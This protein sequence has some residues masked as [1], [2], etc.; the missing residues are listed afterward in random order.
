MHIV[1]RVSKIKSKA[2][3]FTIRIHAHLN[4]FKF[5]IPITVTWYKQDGVLP[6]RSYQEHGT[7]TI[8]NAQHSDSGVY[9]CKAESDDD[10]A[11]EKV[12]IT[13]GSK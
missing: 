5:Q 1:K 12:T 11:E 9:V 2:T 4:H 10:V 13:V 3:K 6:A 7:L 8:S